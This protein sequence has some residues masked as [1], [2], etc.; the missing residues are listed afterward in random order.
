MD[1]LCLWVGMVGGRPEAAAGTGW[2]AYRK[3]RGGQ[4]RVGGGG[5]KVN[6]GSEMG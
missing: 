6:V 5:G 1:K 3:D 4:G 2:A